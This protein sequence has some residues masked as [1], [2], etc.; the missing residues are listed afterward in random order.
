MHIIWQISTNFHESQQKQQVVSLAKLL[1]DI[2]LFILV[3]KGLKLATNELTTCFH[4]FSVTTNLQIF[5][6]ILAQIWLY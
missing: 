1:T 5:R 4:E 6:K 3:W 2:F